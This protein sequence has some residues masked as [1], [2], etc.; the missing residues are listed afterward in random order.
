MIIFDNRMLG[1]KLALRIHVKTIPK[2]CERTALRQKLFSL[3]LVKRGGIRLSIKI[4]SALILVKLC[5]GVDAEWGI[6]GIDL[7]K[8]IPEGGAHLLLGHI[9]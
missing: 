6:F 8:A 9:H 3:L 7:R 4:A 1:Q 2:V 5:P